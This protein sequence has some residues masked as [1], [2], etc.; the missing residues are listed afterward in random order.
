MKRKLKF[1]KR[2]KKELEELVIQA[3]VMRA[4]GDKVLEDFKESVT[5]D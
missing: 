5:G 1:T 3:R 4:I 2:E